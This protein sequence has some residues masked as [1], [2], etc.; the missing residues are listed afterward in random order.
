MITV[1]Q[2]QMS[3]FQN[4]ADE[5]FFRR[6]AEQLRERYPALTDELTNELLGK[7]VAQGMARA[8]GHGFTW[9]SSLFQFLELMLAIA[10]SFDEVP[11]IRARLQDA[12]GTELE[13][14]ARLMDG[15]TFSEWQQ[16]AREYDPGAW[17][18][19]VNQHPVLVD[20]RGEFPQ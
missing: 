13:R 9:E 8:R 1:R 20:L 12:S 10:P 18:I 7:M 19:D 17:R 14:M 11:A 2:A 4:A 6:C 15:T 5:G 3:A 16:A